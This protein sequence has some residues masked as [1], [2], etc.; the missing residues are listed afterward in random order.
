[1]NCDSDGG[2]GGG[3]GDN[4]H[5][6]NGDENRDNSF[7]DSYNLN[8]NSN[9]D[10]LIGHRRGFLHWN[11]AARCVCRCFSTGDGI[12][13]INQASLSLIIVGH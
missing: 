7:N 3:G 9:N 1:M 8:H 5:C 11:C 13:N 4:H 12:G 2:G 10:E 6:D